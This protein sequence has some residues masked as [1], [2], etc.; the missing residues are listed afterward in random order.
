MPTFTPNQFYILDKILDLDAVSLFS[1]RSDQEGSRGPLFN[2][3]YP[4]VATQRK[5]I[6]GT[7]HIRTKGIGFILDEEEDLDD[8]N[9]IVYGASI[10][11]SEWTQISWSRNIRTGIRVRQDIWGNFGLLFLAV[12]PSLYTGTDQTTDISENPDFILIER[13]VLN[14]QPV[15]STEL[16]PIPA[17]LE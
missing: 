14:V 2:F 7:P 11:G 17:S 5:I 16:P 8:S 10:G 1:T 15:S 4:F 12:D 3:N 13:T 9:F 6:S